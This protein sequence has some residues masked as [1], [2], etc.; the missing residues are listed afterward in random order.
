MKRGSAISVGLSVGISM[1]ILFSV[2]FCKVLESYAGIGVG[3]C[4]GIALGVLTFV[5]FRAYRKKKGEI[6]FRKKYRERP[7]ALRREL[8]VFL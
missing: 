7:P 1:S 5:M 6:A 3:I 8:T 4:F 2:V